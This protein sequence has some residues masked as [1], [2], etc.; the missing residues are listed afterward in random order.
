MI[1]WSYKNI[2]LNDKKNCT[3]IIES[4]KYSCDY[5]YSLINS[6]YV[7]QNDNDFIK[8]IIKD[9]IWIINNTIDQSSN[10][11]Y[12]H[13][14]Y[15]L[16][17]MKVKIIEFYCQ[18]IDAINSQL[19]KQIRQKKEKY[20]SCNLIN[21]LIMI[22][23][24]ISLTKYKNNYINKLHIMNPIRQF[25]DLLLKDSMIF[26]QKAYKY[27]YNQSN[28]DKYEYKILLEMVLDILFNVD[29]NCFINLFFYKKNNNLDDDFFQLMKKTDKN[30]KDISVNTNES[31][32]VNRE[33]VLER[34]LNEQRL[35]I[36]FY[37]DLEYFYCA[38][39]KLDETHKRICKK[40]EENKCTEKEFEIKDSI[41][42]IY[43]SYT[44]FFLSK[45]VA[46]YIILKK[47]LK[48][49][50]ND[51]IRLDSISNKNLILEIDHINSRLKTLEKLIDVLIRDMK[52]I[53]TEYE[54]L[55]NL[56]ALNIDRSKIIKNFKS[57]NNVEN[58]I[59]CKYIFD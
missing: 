34:Y 39:E 41:K 25:I 15:L 35:S 9:F 48:T 18:I 58:D 22:Y 1:I 12:F 43:P 16:I 31:I 30:S 36:F 6:K 5:F 52:K 24:I 50:T 4:T 27:T 42:F 7:K 19:L 53:I 55:L 21:Y 51:N 10:P 46:V 38:K 11:F 14:I 29:I 37:M 20:I 44:Q 3:S 23:N 26:S 17:R 2:I 57:S 8:K 47:E 45:Y 28:N 56:R 32:Y 54:C 59:F 40:I 33:D 49:K 13:L